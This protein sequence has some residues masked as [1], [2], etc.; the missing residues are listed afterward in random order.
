MATSGSYDW[1]ESRSN[2]IKNAL[3]LIGALGLGE[4]VSTDANTQAVLVLNAVLKH[5]QT[6]GMP[7]WATEFAYILPVSNTNLVSISSAGGHATLSYVHT[8]TSAVSAS[9]ATS[10]TVDSI[11]GISA[12]D[13]IGVEMSDGTMHWTTVSGAP[14]GSTINLT[15]ALTTDVAVDAHVYAYTTKL[16]RP[17]KIHDAWRRFQEDTVDVPMEKLSRTEYMNLG[18]KESEGTPTQFYYDPQLADGEFNFWPRFS[19][20]DYLIVVSFHR[21]IADMDADANTFDFPKEWLLPIT[22]R[23]AWALSPFYGVAPDERKQIMVEA[24]SLLKD[25]A[26]WDQED[27]HIRFQPRHNG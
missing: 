17:L 9:A 6:L 11:T 1:E 18:T 25:V 15:A 26:D 7:V 23:L 12:S 8:Y 3:Q 4:T 5:M 24:Q 19:D 2:I 13:Y 22:W 16:H 20:G 27:T 14:S 10:I 21:E